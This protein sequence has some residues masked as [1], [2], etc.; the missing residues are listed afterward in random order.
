[1][2][3]APPEFIAQLIGKSE[4]EVKTALRL[5]LE[6]DFELEEEVHGTHIIENV[7]V[8]VDF[9]LTARMH[10]VERGFPAAPI[11]L[12]VKQLSDS[13]NKSVR[14]AWQCIT[15]AQ[16]TFRGQRPPFVVLF[17]PVRYFY[18][19]GQECEHIACL[20]SLLP[21]ANVGQLGFLRNGAWEI[22]FAQDRFFSQTRGLGPKAH[23]A[24]K[25]YVG[26]W[27]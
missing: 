13:D 9:M 1:M 27:K 15:Y 2:Y 26:S 23:L 5:R 6:R 16:S 18:K 21:K 10:L 24:S 7:P 22:Y 3:L 20:H 11:P 14:A 19:Q 17:P 8:V 4:P 12:E 25:R